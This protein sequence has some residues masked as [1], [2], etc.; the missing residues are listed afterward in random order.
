M[1]L[2]AYLETLTK[3]TEH[4]SLKADIKSVPSSIWQRI[5]DREAGKKNARIRLR[6]NWFDW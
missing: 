2:S 1:P 4:F 5:L 6:T 3:C